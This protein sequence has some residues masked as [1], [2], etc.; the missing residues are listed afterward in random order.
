MTIDKR[1]DGKVAL[2]T[3][4]SRGIG[5]AIARRL[6]REGAIAALTYGKDA[7]GALAVVAEIE[8]AGGQGLALQADGADPEAVR[9][10]VEATAERF[11][12][13]DILV[14]NAGILVPGLV[15]DYSTE[16]FDRMIAVN[17]RAPF[18]A[19]KAAV[20]YMRPGS[21]VIN[22]GSVVAHRSATPGSSMYTITKSAFSGLTRGLAHELGAKG[23]T[24]NSVDPGPTRTV[25]STG[26]A[27]GDV[28]EWLRTMIPVGRAGE[29]EEIAGFVAYL[30]GPETGYINGA[31]L[32]IDGG[33]ST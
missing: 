18:M 4:G 14:N 2:V 6:A 27:D 33:M 12:H 31:R 29:P 10:T 19:I 7:A 25:M 16:D 17:V 3:G 11:G 1:L 28:P 5:A 23:I 22:I 26:A 21:R 8:A 9:R 32:L 13:L 15:E 30:A 24:I 20:K